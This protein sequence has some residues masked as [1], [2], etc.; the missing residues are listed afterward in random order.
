[1]AYMVV[2]S[3]Y[4]PFTFDEMIKP[5]Q[6]YETAYRE[7]EAAIDAAREKEFSGSNLDQTLDKTAY[8]MYNSAATSLKGVADELAT[9]GLS[10]ELRGRIKS[11]ARDYK[12]TM[13]TLNDAQDRLIAEQDRRAK[14]GPDYVYQQN[15][16]RIGDFLNGATPNQR[17]ESL[18]K[19]TKDIGTEF[20]ARAQRITQDTWNKAMGSNGRV[21]GGYYDVTTESGLSAAQLDTIL[22]D[23]DTWNSIMKDSSISDSQKALLQ[24]FRNTIESK[25]R[26]LDYNNYDDFDKSR[27][28]EA[29]TLG[30]HYGLGK[31]TH[32]YKKDESYDPLGWANY[33]FRERQY[34]DALAEQEAGWNH[35]P[36]KPVSP[37]TR[38][39]PKEG[40]EI[41]AKGVAVPR[42]TTSATSS[43][44]KPTSSRLPYIGVIYFDK[45]GNSKSYGSDKEWNDSQT[46]F[47][48][49]IVTDGSELNDRNLASLSSIL[50]LGPVNSAEYVLEEASRRGII[51]SVEGNG[52]KQK[53]VLRGT[54][55]YIGNAPAEEE[56]EFN[57]DG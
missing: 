5:Y 37:A 7:Q 33:N 45:E 12:T 8:D 17:G 19:I 36:G 30:A 14:L 57:V 46:R 25:K 48:G 2:N 54:K 22:S 41:N 1:M 47:S 3:R 39:T 49:K 42:G 52:E 53:M 27:I 16:L 26:A 51:V 40:Y 24:G 34:N 31:V 50:G 11:V 20:T 55:T 28:D 56:E 9:N 38:T 6:M 15:N 35:E 29:I 4:N 23:A 18:E 43:S 13:D 44:S 32:E 21:I 10:P